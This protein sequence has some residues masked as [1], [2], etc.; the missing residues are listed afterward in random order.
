[1]NR[2]K[3]LLILLLF[4]PWMVYGQSIKP[5][6]DYVDSSTTMVWTEVNMSCQFPVGALHDLFKV[7]GSVGTGVTVKTVSNWTFGIRGNYCFGGKMRNNEIL[8]LLKDHNGYIYN[9][10]GSNNKTDVENEMEGRYWYVGA[11]FGKIFALDRWKNSGIWLWAD[12]GFAQ[13]KVYLGSQ[14]SD[15]VPLLQDNYRKAFDRRSSG[16]TMSQSIGY[17]FI[18]R[19]RVA[20]FYVGL[21]FRE[22]WTKPDRNYILGVGPTEGTPYRFSGL[23]GIKAA[24]LIPLYEKKKVSTFYTY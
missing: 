17:L 18:R 5:G 1:M 13:H 21:E 14:V 9:S 19:V 15:N 12:F 20:S 3:L 10:D 11:G 4:L 8:D 16:F 2:F 6:K 24:W 23:F 7:N 22:M